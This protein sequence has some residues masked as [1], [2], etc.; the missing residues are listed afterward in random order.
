[1]NNDIIQPLFHEH[2]II[3]PLLDE[4]SHPSTNPWRTIS[5]SSH[6][7]MNSLIFNSLMNSLILQPRLDEQSQ[8]PMILWWIVSLFNHF[9]M[10][11]LIIQT[12]LNEQSETSTTA[13]WTVSFS[14]HSLMNS[15]IFQWLL[16]EQSHHSTTARWTIS[17]SIH[18]L[19]NNVLLLSVSKVLS[20]SANVSFPPV[21][22]IGVI[23][24]AAVT[25]V[26]VQLKLCW[27]I[28]IM[29]EQTTPQNRQP[30]GLRQIELDN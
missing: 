4:Q 15:L 13:W 7:L 10:N 3:Q 8:L 24:A 11:S 21:F 17:S 18:S 23:V 29:T 28:Q 19:M 12:L 5:F 14:S 6:S 1:M 25:D 26:V 30:T 2:P 27:A 9:L 16:N 20:W 22:I